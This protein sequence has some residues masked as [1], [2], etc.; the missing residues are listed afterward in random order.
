MLVGLVLVLAVLGIAYYASREPLDRLV[1][2]AA[3]HQYRVTE[4]RLYRWP[5]CDRPRVDDAV[6]DQTLATRRLAVLAAAVSAEEAGGSG[7]HH[8]LGIALL[9]MGR[10]DDA[11]DSLVAATTA[12]PGDAEAWSD[13]SAA[14]LEWSLR[15]RDPRAGLRAAAA[16]IRALDFGEAPAPMFNLAVS[17]QTLGFHDAS[18]AAIQRYLDVDSR[19]QWADELRARMRTMEAQRHRTFASHV[20]ALR[21]AAARG[22]SDATMAILRRYPQQARAWCETVFLARWAKEHLE[23]RNDAELDFVATIGRALRLV[24]GDTQI[25]DTVS[26][27]RNELAVRNEAT[28]DALARAQLDYDQARR[29]YARR[30][31]DAA[32]PL[33]LAAERTFAKTASPMVHV[34]QYYAATARFDQNG[35]TEAERALRNLDRRIPRT[36]TALRA[37][38]IWA[39][40]TVIGSQ[41]AMYDSMLLYQRASQLFDA[42]GERENAAT[43]RSSLTHALTTLGRNDEAWRLRLQIFA[44]AAEAERTETVQAGLATAGLDALRE[45]D[46]VVA[47]MVFTLALDAQR[48]GPGLNLRRRVHHFVSRAQAKWAR[49]RKNDALSD[50]RRAAISASSIRSRA[51]TDLSFVDVALAEARLVSSSQPAR[52]IALMNHVIGVLESNRK[53]A[54]ISGLYLERARAWRAAGNADAS[55]SDLLH[56]VALVEQMR[57]STSEL[58]DEYIAAEREIFVEATDALERQHPQRAFAIADAGRT[59]LLDERTSVRA[60]VHSV[61]AALDRRSMLVHYTVLGREAV[62]FW[63]TDSEFGHERVP[64]DVRRP[65]AL[66]QPF[67]SRLGNVRRLVIVPD[68]P[69]SGIPFASLR[70]PVTNRKLL[71]DAAVVVTPSASFYVRARRRAPARPVRTRALVVGDPAFDHDLFPDRSRLAGAAA[72]A[73]QIGA[74]YENATVLL[75]SE[76]SAPRF[77]SAA[78][79]ADIV[80]VA[81]HTETG[82][83]PA[84]AALLLARDPDH[85]GAL[86]LGNIREVLDVRDRLV[87]L[88]ACRTGQTEGFASANFAFAFLSTGSET[89]IATVYDI[90]DEASRFFSVTLHRLLRA[91]KSPAEAVREAQLT[92]A[93]SRNPALHEPRNWSAFQVYGSGD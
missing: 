86:T 53:T 93:A 44:A 24:N 56:A 41:G 9:V 13:L 3:A 85:S 21:T 83:D 68:R 49:G 11:I 88:A 26:M 29:L 60:T 25:E 4:G 54:D 65:D 90:P 75:G 32:M 8:T 18:I 39:L 81:A 5:Y 40:G 33:F 61:G 82:G 43:V 23:G 27:I 10:T 72:E 19:S 45:R 76:A 6:A 66:L 47:E 74:L 80:H 16:A 20:D 15:R 70:N 64:F 62:V 73:V 22:D 84:V 46:W 91:G 67:A 55:L 89:V 78:A 51:L 34:V 37:H 87:I 30:E 1:A 77:L 57:G 35:I 59:R 48:P 14:Y 42:L 50:L 58:S 2:A 36:Y 7:S 79:T 69:L 12:S 17:L 92:M 38:V 52:A 31:V 71:Q 63:M 28:V